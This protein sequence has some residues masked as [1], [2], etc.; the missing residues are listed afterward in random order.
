MVYK[1]LGDYPFCILITLAFIKPYRNIIILYAIKKVNFIEPF[2]V[3]IYSVAPS[4]GQLSL[5]YV[6]INGYYFFEWLQ[7]FN[8]YFYI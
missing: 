6:T 3:H 8:D 7:M 4:C 5:N 2:S 1:S